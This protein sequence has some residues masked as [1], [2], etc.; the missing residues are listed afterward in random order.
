MESGGAR[1]YDSNVLSAAPMGPHLHHI[2]KVLVF[3]VFLLIR[4]SVYLYSS[5]RA[6]KQH[7]SL[8]SSHIPTPTVEPFK[9]DPA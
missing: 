7:E 5:M 1:R 3:A 6:L 4:P 2:H 8:V 9:H